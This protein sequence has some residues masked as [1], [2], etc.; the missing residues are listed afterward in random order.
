MESGRITDIH[1]RTI[2]RWSSK[3]DITNVSNQKIGS[4]KESKFMMFMIIV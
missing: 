1:G 3:L 4:I 2:A